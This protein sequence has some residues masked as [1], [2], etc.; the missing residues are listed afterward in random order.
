MSGRYSGL[1]ARRW[2]IW[3]R[4]PKN[5]LTAR[6]HPITTMLNHNSHCLRARD[7]VILAAVPEKPAGI[8]VQETDEY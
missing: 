1:P 7:T 2:K 8:R 4:I 5:S 6:L 3:L